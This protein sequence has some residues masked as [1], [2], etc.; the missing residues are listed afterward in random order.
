MSE[1]YHEIGKNTSKKHV[2]ISAKE[3]PQIVDIT[4]E[5]SNE[6][7]Q[8]KFRA[9]AIN[10]ETNQSCRVK[11]GGFSFQL[12]YQQKYISGTRFCAMPSAVYTPGVI[13][14]C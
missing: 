5:N 8:N 14:E 6:Q 9:I 4:K 7:L 10:T 1:L 13:N 12:W 2:R 11:G 3:G